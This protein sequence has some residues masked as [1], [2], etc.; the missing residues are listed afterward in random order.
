MAIYSTSPFLGPVLGKLGKKLTV[1]HVL[2]FFC[3]P[4]RSLYLRFY[5]PKYYMALDLLRYHYR[6]T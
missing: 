1:L 5:Q 3:L 2:I 6:Q 4:L